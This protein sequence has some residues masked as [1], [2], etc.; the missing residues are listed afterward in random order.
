MSVN[1]FGGPHFTTMFQGITPEYNEAALIPYYRD[2]YYHDSVAGA[3]VDISCTFPFSD[4]AL[5]G[6]DSPDLSIY[7]ECLSRINIRTLMQEV[8]LPYLV[9]GMSTATLVYDPSSKVFQD[10]LMH[11][12]LNT[13]VS[14]QPFHA[15]DPVVKVNSSQVLSQLMNAGSPFLDSILA[16]YPPGVIDRYTQGTVVLDPLTTMFLPRKG[17]ADRASVS[18]LK[19]I[20]PMY[21]LEKVLYRGTLT[22]A[23]KRQRA[24]SHIKAGDENWIPSDAE[25]QGLLSEF[26]RT[27]LDPL[28]AWIITRNGVE[29]NEVRMATEGWRWTDL[30][31]V[32]V[33]YKLRALGISE[34]FLSGE[35]S[36]ATAETAIT[37]FLDSMDAFRQMLTYRIFTR[38]IFPLIAV[39]HGLYKDPS[40]RRQM[41]SVAEI[42]ANLNNHNNLRI[43]QV[44]WF[45]SLNGKDTE[46]QWDMLDKLSE[47]GFTIPLK[48]WAAAASVD[49]S[50]LLQDLEEDQAIKDKLETITGQKA[51]S[52]GVH[53]DSALAESAADNIEAAVKSGTKLLSNRAQSYRRPLLSRSMDPD[54]AVLSKSGKVRHSIVREKVSAS[55][56]N[57]NI[58]KAMRAL[59]DPNHRA[60]VRKRIKAKGVEL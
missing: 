49:I 12:A 53:E 55:K 25:L 42:M 23:H 52:I 13:S 2:I 21:M 59:Q 5:T 43:P 45:K 57:D 35:A 50:S 30:V 36:F 26:Q 11:D 10:V 48:M 20:M 1:A 34:A 27:E 6:L 33:P 7:N 9:D 40:K 31:D 58:I 19:R 24:T 4:L 14:P 51:E 44:N 39:V 28:G 8:A 54:M 60:S 46:S 3:A 56:V 37:V 47:K 18:Y 17:A 32:L 29:V 38:K 41:N 22:E 15:L 16:S